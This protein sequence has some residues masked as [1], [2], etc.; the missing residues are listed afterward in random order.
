MKKTVFVTGGSRGIGRAISKLFSSNE[1][2]VAFCYNNS[3]EK[4]LKSLNDIKVNS[5]NVMAVKCDVSDR[6]QVASA[7][8][9]ITER[10]GGIDVMI[11]NA[12]ISSY[13]LFTD[14]S[15]DE[16]NR[17]CDVNF[18]GVFNCC[19]TVLPEMI[20]KKSGKIIN[21]S[22]M[23]GQIGAS[24]EV[25][26]SAT[27]AAVIGLTQALAKEVAPCG[28][29]VNC[30]CPGVI[31]T[32]ML[33]D[34]TADELDALVCNTPVGR[35]GTPIDIAKTALFLASDE[36]SFITGQIIGVNGGFVI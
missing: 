20:A 15:E 4:A 29:N 34:F 31:T 8:S 12:G 22:S 27:K 7:I 14:V 6:K 23:W 2:A 35:L 10:F 30:I 9:Q 36:S 17:V 21:I 16:F 13:G 25:V 3:I 18:K 33:C 32:D 11:N 1:Y 5:P 19:Q 26:Y 24:C 28:I